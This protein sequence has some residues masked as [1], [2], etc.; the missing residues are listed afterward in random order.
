[1]MKIRLRLGVL[2]IGHVAI[3]PNNCKTLPQIQ[4]TKTLTAT[5]VLLLDAHGL[6]GALIKARVANQKKRVIRRYALIE[7]L[8]GMVLTQLRL[9]GIPVLP[10]FSFLNQLL[11]QYKGLMKTTY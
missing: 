10:L 1:M 2:E 3:C 7:L 8:L 4:I 11:A 5:T 9:N 6:I